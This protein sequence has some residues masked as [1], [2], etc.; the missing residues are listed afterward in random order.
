MSTKLVKLQRK[1]G[2]VQTPFDIY[3]GRRW[4]LGGWDLPQSEFAN[5]FKKGRDGTLEEI[6]EKY[7]AHIRGSP[8]LMRKVCELEG[9]T[10]GCWC[11]P[12]PCH[13]QVLL[14]LIEE[15]C[16]NLNEKVLLY[17]KLAEENG[18]L[19][20]P[21]S[22]YHASISLVLSQKISFR[23]S[24]LIRS[25][26]YSHLGKSVFLPEDTI[27]IEKGFYRE[28]GI[29]DHIGKLIRKI[30]R[31]AQKEKLTFETLAELKGIGDWTIKGAK[32][33]TYTEEPNIFLFEDGYIRKILTSLY[34]LDTKLT[35]S[36]ARKY[37][38]RWSGNETLVSR[39][40]WR[41]KEDS[42]KK[43]FRSQD[44]TREDFY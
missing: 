11:V 7:E 25:K 37:G 20:S 44:L 9:F 27:N 18:Y 35:L 34:E 1:N 41:L 6:L 36:Q 12:E 19:P 16:G 42:V 33:M 39:F 15:V 17:S 38:K 32:I 29:E 30:T 5:P 31:L 23:K 26:L 3:I 43:I 40:L 28:I 8:E 13:G 22:L 14:K 2:V 21:V 10:L 4:T 24:R